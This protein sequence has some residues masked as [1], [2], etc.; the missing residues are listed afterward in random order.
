MTGGNRPKT[1]LF[2]LRSLVKL[3]FQTIFDVTLL[4]YI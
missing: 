1:T 3:N 4:F 2:G